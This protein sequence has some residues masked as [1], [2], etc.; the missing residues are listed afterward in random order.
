MVAENKRGRGGARPN[1]GP[2]RTV[3]SVRWKREQCALGNLPPLSQK[4]KAVAARAWRDKHPGQKFYSRDCR[5]LQQYG[6][7]T[8]KFAELEA[9]RD[10]RCWICG[11][12]PKT[13]LS[14][15]HDHTTGKVRGLLCRNCNFALGAL[16]DSAENCQRAISYLMGS[17]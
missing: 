4:D 9:S 12:L 6:I 7:T 5:L 13:V 15:D 11:I 8:K 14:V 16:R 17:L 1:S 3:G 10:G 2:D